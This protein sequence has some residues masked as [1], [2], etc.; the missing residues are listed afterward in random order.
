VP[1]KFCGK[2]PG[3]TV[4]ST[5]GIHK[6]IRKVRSNGSPLDKEPNKEDSCV[7]TKD[8]LDEIVTMLDDKSQ[9]LLWCLAQETGISKSSTAK[10]MNLLK[11]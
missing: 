4:P 9:N 8:K 7:L 11:I 2:F 5:T 10:V 3:I 1:R 6:L